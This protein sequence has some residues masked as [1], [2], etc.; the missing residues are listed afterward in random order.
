MSG[1]CYGTAFVRVRITRR[2]RARK[3]PALFSL[4]KNIETAAAPDEFCWPCTSA[5]CLTAALFLHLLRPVLS[6][7]R[8]EKWERGEMINPRCCC[9]VRWHGFLATVVKIRGYPSVCVLSWIDVRT[10]NDEV[11]S[12]FFG[13]DLFF[14]RV[15]LG[16]R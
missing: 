10:P 12:V 15:S 1:L 11:V 8:D 7:L 6:S 13:W 5:S 4:T 14:E 9:W 2:D 16:W 3:L